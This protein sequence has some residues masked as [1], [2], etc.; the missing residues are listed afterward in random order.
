MQYDMR[1]TDSD[2]H[3]V[4]LVIGQAVGEHLSVSLLAFGA[5]VQTHLTALAAALQL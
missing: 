1:G 2:G 3:F 5:V 4:P